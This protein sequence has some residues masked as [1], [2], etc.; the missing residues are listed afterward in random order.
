MRP[1]HIALFG[2]IVLLS[3]IAV[4][5][6]QFRPNNTESQ[7]GVDRVGGRVVF[8]LNT[9]KNAKSNPARLQVHPKSS[10][11]RKSEESVRNTIRVQ[12]RALQQILNLT[13]DQ[14]SLIGESYERHQLVRSGY[15]HQIASTSAIGGILKIAIPPYPVA[16]AKLKKMFIDEVVDIAGEKG[17]TIIARLGPWLD[18][19]FRRFGQDSQ[20]V[21]IR[22]LP[23]S[24][25]AVFEV[26]RTL[27]PT[28]VEPAKKGVGLFAGS[29][30]TNIVTYLNLEAGEYGYW[31][32][33][34]R[35]LPVTAPKPP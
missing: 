32:D 29:S 34:I 7:D 23:F 6:R 26:T 10:A 33:Q 2:V 5:V 22:A 17:E 30:S 31:V 35:S 24:T 15:E 27:T 9:Q 13:E 25:E 20:A 28:I 14:I 3:L 11:V 19:E 8:E 1:K 21:E 16:G 18:T 12:L 4:S